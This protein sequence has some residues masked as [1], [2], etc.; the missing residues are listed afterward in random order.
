MSPQEGKLER[1]KIPDFRVQQILSLEQAKNFLLTELNKPG[2]SGSARKRLSQQ[3][4]AANRNLRQLKSG[5]PVK[6]KAKRRGP[7][8]IR[9]IVEI[10]SE[11]K[12]IKEQKSRLLDRRSINPE[13]QKQLENQIKAINQALEIVSRGEYPGEILEKWG[14][15]LSISG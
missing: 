9:S 10:M 12:Q 14:L 13:K 8:L 11:L 5:K 2:T 3:L 4:E 15:K 6:A 7:L 1:V